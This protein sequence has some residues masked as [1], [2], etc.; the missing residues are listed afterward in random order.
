MQAPPFSLAAGVPGHARAGASWRA[1]AAQLLAPGAI[2]AAMLM[3]YMVPFAV[4]KGTPGWAFAGHVA[5][6]PVASVALLVSLV[7]LV[8]VAS[9]RERI[10]TL[11]LVGAA[12]AAA[13]LGNVLTVAVFTGV[14]V[15]PAPPWSNP[16]LWWANM[17]WVTMVLAGAVLV[18]D[19]RVQGAL[20]AAALREVRLRAAGTLRHTAE[21][22]LQAMQA[23]IDPRFLFDALAAVER[24]HDADAAAGNRLLDNLV[25]YLRAV[26]PDLGN[27]HSTVGRELD[28]V[29]LWL[30]IRREV[31]GGTG[32]H[33][34]EE[35]AADLRDRPFPP[36]TMVA[37]A[38]AIL[39]DAPPSA[40]LAIR[41]H[42]EGPLTVVRLDA[43]PFASGTA[44]EPASVQ[45]LRARLT[46]LYG[47]RI[48][49][50]FA[51]DAGRGR[52][53]TVEVEHEPP[54][55]DRR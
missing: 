40:S 28:L 31:A 46:E 26:V 7:A 18:H 14:G 52:R 8:D 2:L 17:G 41:A 37:L 51:S 43:D 48:R 29:R 4:H 39:A 33:A 15:W 11:A 42:D 13:S 44:A 27:V 12:V 25:A 38:E 19:S 3:L 47:D 53:A 45:R 21:T 54:D 10:R 24:V 32:T 34:V 5:F 20:R 30:G 49:L 35:P 23:R 6:P 55:G 9:L 36:V 50:A 1:A 22:R 16:V